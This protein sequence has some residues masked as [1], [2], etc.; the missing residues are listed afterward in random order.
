MCRLS[1][2]YYLLI[3]S[4]TFLIAGKC[5]TIKCFSLSLTKFIIT[6]RQTN[7]PA[8]II[9]SITC[10]FLSVRCIV[11]EEEEENMHF[12]NDIMH[13]LIE[14]KGKCMPSVRRFSSPQTWNVCLKGSV[15]VFYSGGELPALGSS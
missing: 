5:L 7:R 3:D 10:A 2:A 12:D 8:D 13:S 1:T 11:A 9:D 6:L 4:L 14:S 15:V